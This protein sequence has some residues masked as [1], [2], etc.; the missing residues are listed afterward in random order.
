MSDIAFTDFLAVIG[1][2]TC[3]YWAGRVVRLLMRPPGEEEV[4][5]GT[6]Q[7]APTGS[8]PRPPR[9]D[10]PQRTAPAPAGIPPAHVAAI[11]A[12]IAVITGGAHRIVHI[13]DGAGVSWSAEGRRLHQT[14]HTP[15]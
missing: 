15:H 11:T 10:A 2:G 12:A 6:S 5:A 7:S 4:E 9:P 8:A 13:D 14:S 1:A 3:L